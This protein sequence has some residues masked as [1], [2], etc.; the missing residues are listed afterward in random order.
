[1]T[2]LSRLIWTEYCLDISTPARREEL[3]R[4]V[5]IHV[6]KDVCLLADWMYDGLVVKERIDKVEGEV[7]IYDAGMDRCTGR[8]GAEWLYFDIYPCHAWCQIIIFGAI[9]EE[10]CGFY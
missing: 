6:L 4:S 3:A 5:S 9:G 10:Q 1:M 8:Q 2:H 7:G